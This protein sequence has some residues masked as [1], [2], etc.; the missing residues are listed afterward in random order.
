MNAG[1]HTLHLR[2]DG[3]HVA[4]RFEC[5]DPEACALPTLDPDGAA[6]DPA[7][8]WL[9]GQA[10]LWLEDWT[11]EEV[12]DSLTLD[13]LRSPVRVDVTIPGGFGTDG[14]DKLVLVV[15]EP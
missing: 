14:P 11:P 10:P 12:L 8:C 6:E 5:D 2:L 9:E 15:V 1:V 13:P 4:W 3:G 7:E